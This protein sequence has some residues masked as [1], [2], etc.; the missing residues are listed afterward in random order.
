MRYESHFPWG[1]DD[2][3]VHRTRG[4]VYFVMHGQYLCGVTVNALSHTFFCTCTII[5]KQ[6]LSYLIDYDG[7]PNLLKL[8]A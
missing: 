4:T 8:S 1:R 2:T 7:S 3:L 5:A 6:H